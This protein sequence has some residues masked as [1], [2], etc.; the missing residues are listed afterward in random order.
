MGLGPI[1]NGR[2]PSSLII[3]RGTQT[4]QKHS[5]ELQ[6]IRDQITT[7]QQFQVPGE[8]A[9]AAIRTIVL[10]KL[11][12]R[13][14]QLQTNLST[15]RSLLSATEQSLSGISNIFNETQSIILNGVGE[16]TTPAEKNVL[17]QE[18]NTLIQSAVNSANTNFRGRYLFA[19]SQNT[20]Q[21]F[22]ITS[23]GV[24]Y[25]GD[26]QEINTFF[27]RDIVQANNINP[28]EVLHPFVE[29]EGKNTNPA[30][31][32]TTPLAD[33]YNGLGVDLGLIDVTVDTGTP[34]TETI[35]LTGS[36]NIND[37]KTRIEAAFGGQLTVDI[38][39][40]S[41]SGLRLTPASGTVAVADQEHSRTAFLLGIEATASAQVIGN[42]LDPRISLQTSLADLNGGTG[43]GSTTG[44]GLLIKVGSKQQVID[45][46]STSTVEDLFNQLKASGLPIEGEINA[47][48][49]GISI[50]SRLSGADF[51]IG[52]NAGENATLLG[53]R[54]YTGTTKLSSLNAGRGVVQGIQY[55]IPITRRDGTSVEVNINS[56]INVQDV[57]DAIN[58]VDPGNLVASLN[59]TGNGISIID[60]SGTGPLIITENAQTVSLGING[61]ET[62]TD[63]TI[64]LTGLD[65]NPRRSTGIFDILYRL[66]SAL[67]NDDNIEL[68]Q[69]DP[70]L[71]KEQEQIN[72]VRGQIGNRLLLVDNL[73]NFL[74]DQELNIK[75]SISI[76]FDAD[77]TEAITRLNITQTLLQASQQLT[78]QG[79]SSSILNF[80]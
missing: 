76:E 6:R 68:S 2:V 39:P 66:E 63:N 18:V 35:D 75:E 69:L 57:I 3:Q 30:L 44:T 38:D 43:I 28:R 40:T 71:K 74:A 55:N 9:S 62:G 25:R 65:N 60:N 4:I 5:A 14:S 73:D 37:V 32:L 23:E 79:F 36:E 42:D 26:K 24:L 80:L 17:A 1:L 8:N 64:P 10:Q 47:T 58:A 52:E 54:T 67:E 56:A 20:T 12:E 45:L 50:L 7:G 77:L 70:L 16:N 22:E 33:L 15:N 34:Q 27:S 21:P 31:T 72:L 46:S 51:S 59:S 48:G 13:Q 29:V 78:A 11:E 49:D 19:G 53:I 61:S 41:K